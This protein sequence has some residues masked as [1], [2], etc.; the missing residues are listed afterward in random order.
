MMEQFDS[1]GVPGNFFNIMEQFDSIGALGHFT[2]HWSLLW[3]LHFGGAGTTDSEVIVEEG[4][5][6]DD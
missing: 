1:M 6:P 2:I 3:F 4:M 5:G